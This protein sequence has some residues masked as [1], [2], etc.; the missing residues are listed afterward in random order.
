MP[1]PRALV[2]KLS[3][4]G[5][6]IHQMPALSD[7]RQH[8]PDVVIDWV[9]E[10]AYAPL[11]RLHPAVR[12]VIPAGLRRLRGRPAS[13]AGWR[14]LAKLVARLRAARFDWVVD[15][16]GLLKSAM[17][18]R[19][20]D[21]PRY[22]YDRQSIREPLASALLDARVRVSRQ[23]HAV[24]RIRRL[25]AT[26]FGYLHGGEI[27]YGL[28]VDADRPSWAPRGPYVVGL[29]AT[30][31]AEKCW[32]EPCWA[33]LASYLAARGIA[34]VFPS[35]TPAEQATAARLAA[36]APLATVAPA[37]TLPE[38]AAL[39]SHASGAVG[40]DTGLAHLSV[41]VGAPTV[42][43]YVATDASLTGLVGGG[44]IANLG[45]PG[46]GPSPDA[47]WAALAPRLRATP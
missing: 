9:V 45:H 35:G 3:S 31:R 21:G 6:V 26:T 24:E 5:D 38:A 1:S 37:L 36:T 7:L 25:F 19:V 8:R 20:A 13:L 44:A 15:S 34:I 22:G 18:A 17:L 14:A 10:E 43:V 28:A 32:P 33:R 2:V 29:H 41:A 11:V 4:L 12:E 39:L 23:W 47:V 16:Q 30:S 27:H 46:S 42:G 40:V